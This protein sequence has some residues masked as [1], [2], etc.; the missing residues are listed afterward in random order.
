MTSTK[1]I[2]SIIVLLCPIPQ[3][4][5]DFMFEAAYYIVKLFDGFC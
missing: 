3:S 1:Y 4:A 5:F 2:I